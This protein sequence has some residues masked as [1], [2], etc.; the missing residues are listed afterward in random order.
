[1]NKKKEHLFEFL[2][3]SCNSSPCQ[4]NGQCISTT[5]NCSSTTCFA[6]CLCSPGTTGTYCEQQDSSCLTLPCLNGGTCSI[7][8]ITNIRYCQCPLNTIGTR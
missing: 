4:N 3:S 2:V 5:A 7:N 1:M 8:P 6:S